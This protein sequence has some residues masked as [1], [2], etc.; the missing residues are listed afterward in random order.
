VRSLAIS[1]VGGGPGTEID[2]TVAPDLS[3]FRLGNRSA[4]KNVSVK[5]FSVDKAN[6]V[7]INKN[8]GV[9]LPNNHDL[10]VTVG[11]WNTVDLNVETLAF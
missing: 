10:I 9:V 7:P 6:N 1:G 2:I 11:N 5:A 8:A 4:V 3:L